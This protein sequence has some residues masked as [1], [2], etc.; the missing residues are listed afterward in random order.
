MLKLKKE[1]VLISVILALVLVMGLVYASQ[2]QSNNSQGNNG[3]SNYSGNNSQGNNS[4][5]NTLQNRTREQNRTRTNNTFLP[6]QQRTEEECPETCSCHGAVVSC[7]TESGKTM[8]I[9]AGNSGNVITMEVNKM[10]ANTKLELQQD[11]NNETNMN[12]FHVKLSNGRL[13]EIK[14]MPDVAAERALERLRLKVC[15]ETN[16]CTLELKEVGNQ[17]QEKLAYELQIQ[18]HTRVLGIFQA[19]VQVR[20]EIDAENGEVKTHKPWWMFLATQPEE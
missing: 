8:T 16:N 6:W 13:S 10:Q 20:A 4:G 5:N 15:N 3:N 18:R 17:N 12:Q 9:T 7:E 2:N 11:G 19:K 1:M 14:I